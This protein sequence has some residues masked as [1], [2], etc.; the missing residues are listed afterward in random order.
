MTY[1]I[2]EGNLV[3]L[4][5]LKVSR[6]GREYCTARVA[7]NSRRA[8]VDGTWH[9]IGT[10]YYQLTIMGQLGVKLTEIAADAGNIK[11]LFTGDLVVRDYVRK[12][13]S[14]GSS[15][16]VMVDHIAVS[17]FGQDLTVNRRTREATE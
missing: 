4:P 12:D 1:I 15:N 7:C 2:D 6:A 14:A 10:A 8:D 3:A 16:D 9:N 17:L 11:L 5:E 13:G